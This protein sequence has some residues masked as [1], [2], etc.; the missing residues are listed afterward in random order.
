MRKTMNISVN[1][2]I[3]DYIRERAESYYFGSV[4]EYIRWLVRNDMGGK[5]KTEAKEKAGTR[6]RTA[7]E[8]IFVGLFEEFLDNYYGDRG[9]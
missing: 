6:L 1:D 9:R 8:S 7:N 2:D 3:Y 4:S 5:I